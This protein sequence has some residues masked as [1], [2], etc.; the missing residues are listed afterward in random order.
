MDDV[1]APETELD[2]NAEFSVA[3]HAAQFGTAEQQAAVTDASVE[4]DAEPIAGPVAEHPAVTQKR[5]A[6]TGE[7]RPGRHRARS[8]Q[9]GPQDVGRINELT[10]KW[11]S[12]E[13]ER[14]AARAELAALRAQP[15]QS[16]QAS[17]D[18]VAGT[19]SRATG[20]SIATP[21][22]TQ[23]ADD[24]PRP[25]PTDTKYVDGRYDD[26]YIEDVSRWSARQEHQAIQTKA[27]KRSAEEA[28]IKS[29]GASVDR[30]RAKYTDYDA[31]AFLADHGIPEGS[32][33]DVFIYEDEN[34]GDVLYHLQKNRA[35]LRDILGTSALNQI[36]ALSLLSQRLG[37]PP[38]RAQAGTTGS[39]ASPIALVTPRPPNPV[40]TGLARTEESPPD[41]DDL[42]IAEH[43][44]HY[45]RR[46]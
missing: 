20:G 9:A 42:S 6:K 4:Q 38:S 44:K 43:S 37:S 15:S 31:V 27:T 3:D 10:G 17:R 25:N 22:A 24:D 13:Q 1:I 23:K 41:R 7:F 30:A 26:Q 16:P 35:E 14:D 11:R 32:A 8:Q 18:P 36:K 33:T 40:R 2:V 12:A 45:G 19:P 39:A 21:A 34:G 29:W 28:K 5:D 46:R